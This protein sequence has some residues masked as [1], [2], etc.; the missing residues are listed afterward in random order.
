MMRSF[1]ALT[2]AMGVAGGVGA[3]ACESPGTWVVSAERG[4]ESATATAQV[5][6]GDS[7]HRPVAGQQVR[8]ALP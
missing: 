1:L 4:G 2:A 8:L 3:G 5:G 6:W 7:D